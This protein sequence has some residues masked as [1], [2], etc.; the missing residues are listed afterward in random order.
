MTDISVLHAAARER[1]Q[2]VAARADRPS[3]RR[4]AEEA[5]SPAR[6][7]AKVRNLQIRSVDDEGPLEYRGLATVY[8]AGY[9]MWDYYGPYTEIVSAGAG[10]ET[11]ARSDLD[12]PLVLQHADL[13]RIARTTNG[14]L[15]LADTDEGLDV[16]APDLDREDHDVQY[17]VPKLRSGL[18]DEMSFKFR[19]T[20]G[21]WSPDYMEYRI[22]KYDIHRGDVAIVGYGANPHTSGSGLRAVGELST[23]LR[24][25]SDEEARAALDVLT[26]RGRPA[27]R[28]PRDLISDEDTRPRV[29]H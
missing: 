29:I 15:I 28:S 4:C 23:V 12:V 13:R 8:E 7:S 1:S 21:Q 11:L 18:I 3:Q 9:E 14:S 2:A 25:L 24:G 10:A 16:H 20:A 22:N 27:H 17:I 19:I 26:A 5:G 6:M